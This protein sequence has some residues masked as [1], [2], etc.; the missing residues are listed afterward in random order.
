MRPMTNMRLG[1][2]MRGGTASGRGGNLRMKTGAVPGTSAGTQAAFL[3]Q[4]NISVSDRPVTGQGI[5]GMKASVGPGRQ[6]QDSSFYIGLLNGK[7]TDITKEI[8]KIKADMDTMQR[9]A[10]QYNQ[11]ERKYESLLKEVRNL[12][13]TLADYNLAMDKLRTS[14]DP[15]EV[16][17]YQANLEARNRNEA[18]EIDKVFLMKEQRNQGTQELEMQIGQVH[19]QAEAKI[20]QLEPAKLREYEE[21]IQRSQ[22]LHQEGQMREQELDKMRHKIHELEAIV[23]GSGMREEYNAEERK[24]QRL[25]KDVA[26]LEEDMGI[27]QMDPKDAHARLLDKVKE[28]NRKTTELESRCKEIDAEMRKCKRQHQELQTDLEDR[29]KGNVNKNDSH[30]YELLFQRDAEMSEFL[31]NYD[32]QRDETLKDQEATKQTI[33]ALLEHISSGIGS[34]EEMPSAER[35]EEMKDE[36]SFKTKQLET[37]Q[38]TMARLQQQRAKRIQEMQK[39][40]TL[41]QKIGIELEQLNGKMVSMKDEMKGFEDIEGLRG[42]ATFTKDELEKLREK[43]IARRGAIKQQVAGLSAQV[44]ATKKTLS[45]NETSKNLTSLELK[46]RH[47]E[48]NIFVMKEYVET[49]GRE[50]DFESLKTDVM[51]MCG[52]LNEKAV[53]IA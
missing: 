49:K 31:Q 45:M 38:Q 26:V 17:A 53:E 51:K 12:E 28:D 7:I 39:I 50:T 35:L 15:Q 8:R 9:D 34:S 11:L 37:S 25:R 6:V 43:Y 44:D 48:Q 18:A 27:A 33:V 1:T 52:N 13:G 30:K 36:V 40:N 14:T 32:S 29:E 16:T 42:R 24:V 5:A 21:L 41:D 3:P 4:H 19:Q 46:L 22:G 10:G 47:Y 20:K 23:R 2:G